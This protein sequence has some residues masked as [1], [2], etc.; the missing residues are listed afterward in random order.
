[1]VCPDIPSRGYP[2]PCRQ[3]AAPL[4]G[5]LS[6]H[7][8]SALWTV[9]DSPE[10]VT[11]DRCGCGIWAGVLHGILPG[12]ST[13]AGRVVESVTYYKITNTLTP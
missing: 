5:P 10:Q 3:S 6:R 9:K 12:E 11:L 7:D 2:H 1:M 4:P 8:G 13:E